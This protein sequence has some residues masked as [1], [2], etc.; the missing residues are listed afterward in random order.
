MMAAYGDSQ[1]I[2]QVSV[3]TAA[4]CISDAASLPRHIA[5]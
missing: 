5:F 1:P 2:W 3:M 4:E